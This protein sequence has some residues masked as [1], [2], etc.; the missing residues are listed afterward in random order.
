MAHTA[1]LPAP[2]V[3]FRNTGGVELGSRLS[4]SLATKAVQRAPLALERVHDVKRGDRLAARVLS[5]GDRVADHILQEHLE[6]A[7]RLLVDEAADALDAAAARQTPD[8]GLGDACGAL[9][10]GQQS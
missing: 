1:R 6:H 8:G 3:V 4:A 2:G 10:A 9:L 5:V 7:A